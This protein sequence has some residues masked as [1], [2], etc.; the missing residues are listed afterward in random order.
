MFLQNFPS[1]PPFEKFLDPRLPFI[2]VHY[3]SRNSRRQFA[4]IS[5][6]SSLWKGWQIHGENVKTVLSVRHGS[7]NIIFYY[8]FKENIIPYKWHTSS[9]HFSG[10]YCPFFS[11]WIWQERL[12]FFFTSVNLILYMYFIWV[13]FSSKCKNIY[14]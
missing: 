9:L 13:N 10:S 5:C 2:F 14:S 12:S 11:H 8:K 1:T 6:N 3:R 7:K 4:S